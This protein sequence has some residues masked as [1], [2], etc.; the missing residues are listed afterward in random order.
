[1]QTTTELIMSQRLV[2]TAIVSILSAVALLS[3]CATQP[4]LAGAQAK[5][6][7]QAQIQQSVP[8]MSEPPQLVSTAKGNRYRIVETTD[9]KGSEDE[10]EIFAGAAGP[11]NFAGTA[12]KAVKI[13]LLDGVTPETFASTGALIE[14][15][16]SDSKMTNHTPPIDQGPN[17]RRVK[18]EER[19]AI[20]SGFLYA[21]K[22]ESDNDFHL[23]FGGDP[24]AADDPQYFTAEI[25]GLPESGPDRAR[26]T[27][28]RN[29]FKAFFASGGGTGK[30]PGAKYVL[31]DP[32]VPV[33]IKGPLF[34]DTEHAGGVVGPTCCK[35]QHAWEVHP[36]EEIVFEP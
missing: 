3:G 22:K 35:A 15:L 24:E 12:R 4:K 10:E 18:E 16:P 13:S 33:R 32:P 21:T 7:R 25:T 23:I 28:A 19:V 14:T 20:V 1:M 34:Y 6:A 2:L 26:L 27:A 36:I 11:D 29:Q 5:A 9:T 30:L 31:F 17:S 8:L